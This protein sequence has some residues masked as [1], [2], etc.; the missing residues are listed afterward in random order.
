[1]NQSQASSGSGLILMLSGILAGMF[2]A[3]AV[4]ILAIGTAISGAV[5]ALKPLLPKSAAQVVDTL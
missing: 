1:M 4:Q 3:H 2:S 5:H